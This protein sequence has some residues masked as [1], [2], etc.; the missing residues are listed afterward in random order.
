MLPFDD[1]ACCVAAATKPC[2]A[3]FSALVRERLRGCFDEAPSLQS[4]RN[5]PT[6]FGVNLSHLTLRIANLFGRI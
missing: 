3:L 5:R 4:I 1:I 2:P 6:P